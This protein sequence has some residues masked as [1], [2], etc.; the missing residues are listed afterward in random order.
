LVQEAK[1]KAN[2]TVE[3]T[4]KATPDSEAKSQRSAAHHIHAKAV[5]KEDCFNYSSGQQENR[6]VQDGFGACTTRL[7]K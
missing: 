7:P 3:L 2:D 4:L 6:I 1:A 5:R